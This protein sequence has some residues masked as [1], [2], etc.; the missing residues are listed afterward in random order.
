MR[1][2][3]FLIST[4]VLTL[5]GSVAAFA[6][7]P[8][9]GSPPPHPMM[10]HHHP[11]MPFMRELHQLGLS[12][13]QKQTLRDYGR[14]E[15]QSLKP[16]M[17]ALFQARLAFLTAQPGTSDFATAQAN[18]SLAASA[19]AQAR[20]QAEADF[21]TKAYG[22]LTDAQKAQLAQLQA[23]HKARAQQ[24]LEK[25]AAQGGTPPPPPEE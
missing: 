18:L 24:W 21:M 2:T 25:H 13:A 19:A 16:Q 12:D 10:R 23:Q 5:G 1:K 9:D 14:Q 20:V 3:L 11:P 7:P 17:Q 4:L 15:M 6:Q 8:D 22:V